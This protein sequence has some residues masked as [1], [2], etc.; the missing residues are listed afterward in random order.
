LE[1][2]ERS[3]TDDARRWNWLAIAL[4]TLVMAFS[5]FSYAAAFI[6]T[7][8]DPEQIS[9]QLIGVGLALAPI[10]FVVLGFVSRNHEAPRR[11]LMAMGLLLAIGLTVGLIAPALGAATGFAV[12]GAITLN[13]PP[14]EDVGRWRALAVGVTVLY[15]FVLLVAITPAGVF[16]GGLL[17][18]LML[19]FA[20]EYAVWRAGL[21]AP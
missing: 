1:D 4:A 16:S 5:Y 15:L 13:R 14:V 9:P 10:V 19:G 6:G 20:D 18:L 2:F 17:P 21:S 7:D 12:G 8:D 3:A 11:I